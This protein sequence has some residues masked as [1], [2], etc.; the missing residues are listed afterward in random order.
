MAFEQNQPVEEQSDDWDID[1][2]LGD[3]D[4][5]VEAEERKLDTEVQSLKKATRKIAEKQAE[6]ERKAAVERLTSDFYSNAS[7]TE[8]ELADVLLPGLSEPG[9]VKAALDLA[10]AK[11]AKLDGGNKPVE[12]SEESD[13]SAAAAFA[14]PVQS[15]A[16]RVEDPDEK[17]LDRIAHGDTKAALAYWLKDSV[18]A[19]HFRD[20]RK[21]R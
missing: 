8:R 3:D 10:K 16:P 17:I 5:V 19:D 13:D 14:P 4:P 1:E 7:D 18:M 9:K 21:G 6:G 11:A 12:E 20:A 15:G 2:L